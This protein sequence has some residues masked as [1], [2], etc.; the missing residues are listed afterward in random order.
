M[1]LSVETAVAVVAGIAAAL[2]LDWAIYQR[3]AEGIGAIWGS[4][5]QE[6]YRSGPKLRL[7]LVAAAGA[8]GASASLAGNNLLLWIVIGAFLILHFSVYFMLN[9]GH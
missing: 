8:V 6:P 4:A 5:G 7:L 3:M 9:R 1:S 2:V